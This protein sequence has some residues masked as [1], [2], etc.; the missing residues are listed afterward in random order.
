VVEEDPKPM[1]YWDILE[2]ERSLNNK[3][4]KMSFSFLKSPVFYSNAVMVLYLFFCTIVKVYP[5]IAWVST[6]VVALNFI[7]TNYFHRSAV[8]SAANPQA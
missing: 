2:Q 7:L 6:V 5:D 3:I 1:S 8:L 4:Y